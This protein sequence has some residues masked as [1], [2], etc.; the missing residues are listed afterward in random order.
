MVPLKLKSNVF[1]TLRGKQLELRQWTVQCASATGAHGRGI[2]NS[3]HSMSG[4]HTSL[5]TTVK[6]CSS[7]LLLPCRKASMASEVESR[8]SQSKLHS[9]PLPKSMFWMDTVT[10]GE[11][12][13]P[14]IHSTCQ[15]HDC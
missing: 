14:N 15:L 5:P 3:S 11:H 7:P 2:V 1:E 12:P 4:V 6:T 13:Q 8:F 10:P 9:E